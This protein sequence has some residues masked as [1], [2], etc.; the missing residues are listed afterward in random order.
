MTDLIELYRL[1]MR[2]RGLSPATIDKRSR[3][4]ALFDAEVGLNCTTEQVE[5]WLDGRSL[6]AKSRSV[7]LSHLA[8]FYDWANSRGRL[9]ASPVKDIDRPRLHRQLPRPMS[10]ADITKALKGAPPTMRLWLLLASLE[11]LRCMEIAGLRRSD[12]LPDGQ[13]RIRGKGG[14]ERLVPIHPEVAQAMEEV[15]MS[16]RGPLFRGVKGTQLNAG[17]ISHHIGRHLRERGLKGGAHQLRHSFATSL[18]QS[19]KDLRLTQEMLGHS[20]PTT[21]AIYCAPNLDA[22]RAAVSALKVS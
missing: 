6:T 5:A 3:C 22:A 20:S 8:C 11:G 4:L 16:A 21:T 12:I 7:W 14:H 10:H 2:R 18:Y 13:L 15:K 9:K 19:T 17:D 1:H